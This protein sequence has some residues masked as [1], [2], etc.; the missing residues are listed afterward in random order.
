[1]PIQGFVEISKLQHAFNYL[2]YILVEQTV[3]YE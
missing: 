1:M 2:R 3:Y